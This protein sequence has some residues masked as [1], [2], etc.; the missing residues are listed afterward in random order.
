LSDYGVRKEVTLAG[1][2]RSGQDFPSR[3]V[4]LQSGKS[5]LDG[6]ARKMALQWELFAHRDMLLGGNI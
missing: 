4:S 2:F 1:C 3:L 6:S 5:P